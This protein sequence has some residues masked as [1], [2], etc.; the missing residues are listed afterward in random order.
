MDR[1]R[2]EP[3]ALGETFGGTTGRR[4]KRDRHGLR[5]QD[6]EDGVDQCRLTDAG[7]AGDY[8]HLGGESNANSLSLAIGERHLRPLL[9]PRDSLVGIDCRPRRSSDC[10]RL[11]LF[12]NLP[13]GPVEAGEEDA[14]A[15][16]EVIGDYRATFELEGERR[17]D[18]LC[19]HLKKWRNVACNIDRTAYTMHLPSRR[20]GRC[21]HRRDRHRL[22]RRWRKPD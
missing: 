7:T 22:T 18:E 6:L 13:F 1:F 5:D 10:E 14:T 8:Q 17:F 12:G 20:A 19:W 3:G 21:C 15:A 11:E 9:D 16:F 4:T 2:L